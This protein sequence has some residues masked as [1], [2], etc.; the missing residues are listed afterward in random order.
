MAEVHARKAEEAN[1]AARAIDQAKKDKYQAVD[2]AEA[3]EKFAISKIAAEH[4][5]NV[6]S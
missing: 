1:S 4:A 5:I 2:T 3:R 6:V